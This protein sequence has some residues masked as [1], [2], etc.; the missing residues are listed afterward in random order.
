M[1]LR[2]RGNLFPPKPYEGGIGIVVDDQVINLDRGYTDGR[3]LRAGAVPTLA[4]T[5]Y[6]LENGDSSL[7]DGEMRFLDASLTALNGQN[8]ASLSAVA[9]IEFHRYGREGP[10]AASNA[11]ED[12]QLFLGQARVGG[13]IEL[14][15]ANTGFVNPDARA[16][17]KIT[18]VATIT[19]GRRCGVTWE[20]GGAATYNSGFYWQAYVQPR[21]RVVFGS[22][23]KDAAAMLGPDFESTPSDLVIVSG[24][25]IRPWGFDTAKRHIRGGPKSFGSYTVKSSTTAIAAGDVHIGALA[26]GVRTI[27]LKQT[28]TASAYTD[29]ESLVSSGERLQIGGL[30]VELTSTPQWS[31]STG[32]Q[33]TT[34]DVDG[35][36]PAASVSVS[37]DLVAPYIERPVGG[38]TGDLLTKTAGGEEWATPADIRGQ[39]I[40]TSSALPSGSGITTWGTSPYTWTLDSGAPTG[41]STATDT[42]GDRIRC[43]QLRPTIRTIGFIAESYVGTVKKGET[44]FPWGPPDPHLNTALPSNSGEYFEVNYGYATSANYDEIYLDDL[45]GDPISA[46]TTCKIFLCEV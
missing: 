23:V 21:G 31:D 26:S 37:V 19:N 34:T 18:S 5:L 41:F 7:V 17:A 39:L 43:P 42:Q 28:T 27:N 32:W 35:T 36:A 30:L 46:S 22:D 2:N 3:Y 10:A 14:H 29:F 4:R 13:H 1:V 24:G 16:V 12:N 9:Y 11:N 8:A 44:F 6:Y 20:E 33:F 25:V 15:S 45:Y 40:A 38:S